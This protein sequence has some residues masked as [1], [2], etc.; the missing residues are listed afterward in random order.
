LFR[1]NTCSDNRYNIIFT[2]Y[3]RQGGGKKIKKIVRKKKSSALACLKI[4]I[5]N[6]REEEGL[7]QKLTS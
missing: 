1:I 6:A 7:L 3:N 4:I 5:H 2:R